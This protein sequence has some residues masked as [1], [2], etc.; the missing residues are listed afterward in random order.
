MLAH[1]TS[2]V[3]GASVM[4]M[5]YGACHVPSYLS[6]GIPGVPAARRQ[7]DRLRPEGRLC[8]QPAGDSTMEGRSWA[9]KMKAHQRL[10]RRKWAGPDKSGRGKGRE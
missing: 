3:S 2:P 1:E 10:F 9:M 7:E 8:Q 5:T 6:A 4:G